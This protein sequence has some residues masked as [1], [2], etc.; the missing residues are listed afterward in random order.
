MCCPAY[1]QPTTS[2]PARA[3]PHPR[4]RC[5]QAAHRLHRRL[6]AAPH[7][8]ALLLG[9]RHSCRLH[10]WA[11]CAWAP[12]WGHLSGTCGRWCSG[13]AGSGWRRATGHMRNRG[14]RR[15]G[16][17]A[18]RT[19]GAEAHCAGSL[20]RQFC[21][22][23][24][25]RRSANRPN[26]PRSPKPS[27]ARP[28]THMFL[29]AISARSTQSLSNTRFCNR[30]QATVGYIRQHSSGGRGHGTAAAPALQ[31]IQ[32]MRLPR[33]QHSADGAG[34]PAPALHPPPAVLQ[35]LWRTAQSPGPGRCGSA[36]AR[37]ARQQVGRGGGRVGGEPSGQQR[38]S[39]SAQQCPSGGACG[40]WRWGRNTQ[41]GS[42]QARATCQHASVY[43]PQPQ[44][45]R[46]R[47]DRQHPPRSRAGNAAYCSAPAP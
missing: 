11:G 24:P 7:P 39:G 41:P 20:A 10:S 5:L 46:R 43:G 35:R 37:P 3:A 22:T 36:S 6:A 45:T 19:Y 18:N 40:T 8:A 15:A 33:P 47:P 30:R 12:G 9:S 32:C 4:T 16:S 23:N 38:Q 26:R 34:R 27:A 42:Q 28:Q 17:A 29:C 1:H 21:Q 13:G 44:P 2:S 31:N 25:A 14:K